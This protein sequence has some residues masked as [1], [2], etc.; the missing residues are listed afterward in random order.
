M[1][2]LLTASQNQ[3][4]AVALVVMLVIALMEG[5]ASL[6]GAGLSSVLDTLLPE[7]DVDM[8]IDLD[9][10][11][12]TPSAFTRF[13]GW[14]R[15]GKVPVLMLLVIFLTAFGLT[16][17]ALQSFV[18]TTSGLYLPGWIAVL[19]AALVSFPIVRV[20]GGVLTMIMPKDETDAVAEAT[21][22]GRVAVI[23][24][25]EASSGSPAEAKLS[26]EH[27]HSHYVMVEPDNDTVRFAQGSKVLITERHGA[28]FKAIQADSD[29][30]TD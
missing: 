11:N 2:E 24:L 8:D 3:A 23:T 6:M 9:G 29:A 15:V 25:G 1:M 22:I 4:F 26:D 21:F 7:I 13:L 19:P 14:L 10:P 17:L 30:L 5:V 20:L 12:I 28:T 16:G 27:G 18:H